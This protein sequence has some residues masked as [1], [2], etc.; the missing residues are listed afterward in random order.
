M[1]F[2]HTKNADIAYDTAGD[3]GSPVLLVM[4]F[5]LPGQSWRHQI[6]TLAAQHRV[7][8]FDQ[9][10][11][12]QTRAR[13]GA[14][15]MSL[16]ASDALALMD[17]LGWQRAHVVGVSMGGMVAQWLALSA[18]HRVRSLSLIATH[19]GGVRARLPSLRGTLAFVAANIGPRTQ[20]HAALARLLFP[21]EYIQRTGEAFI[22]QALREEFANP[23]PLRF[24]L[25]QLAA[26]G[27]HDTRRR[28]HRLAGIPTL[29]VVPGQDELVRPVANQRLW[30]RIPGASIIEFPD[31][32]HGILRQHADSLNAALL[33]HFQQAD[34][35]RL[36]K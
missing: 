24:R 9:R 20:R 4:G 22:R 19:A 21:L 33:R 7:A 30:R 28:L 11:S 23:P 25:S 1:K 18:L 17:H 26:V 3:E 12:G 32:G 35:H 2:L 36:Q 31:A 29:V 10:G 5:G 8:W 13:A 15:S 27:R 16:L 6:P 34:A 14:Y